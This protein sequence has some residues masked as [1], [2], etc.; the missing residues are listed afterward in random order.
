MARAQGIA[1]ESGTYVG[2]AMSNG[3]VAVGGSLYAQTQLLA[4]VTLG[5]G[6]IVI[7]LASVIVGESLLRFRGIWIALVGCVL[8]SI[9][10]SASAST[11]R[12]PTSI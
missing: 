3:L 11:S 6:V 9:P 5:S 8:G 4:D 10:A 2:M 12:P 1:T 7:G